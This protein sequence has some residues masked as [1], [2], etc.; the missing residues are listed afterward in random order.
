MLDQKSLP[1]FRNK[2]A[3]SH[4]QHHAGDEKARQIKQPR[5]L[6]VEKQLR[7]G[8]TIL[9]RPAVKKIVGGKGLRVGEENVANC[10]K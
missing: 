10:D 1:Q 2:R 3:Q 5:K 8:G 7:H 4:C 6:D 9:Q